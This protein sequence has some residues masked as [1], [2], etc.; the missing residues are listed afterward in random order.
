MTFPANPSRVTNPLAS[1]AQVAPHIAG[2]NGIGLVRFA[3][4]LFCA[5]TGGDDQRLCVFTF[6]Y[7]GGKITILE[8]YT[9]NPA[10]NAAITGNFTTQLKESPLY[11]RKPHFYLGTGPTTQYLEDRT[12]IHFTRFANSVYD[13]GR[14]RRILY[15][16]LR[17]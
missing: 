11:K 7:E 5:A 15:R 2:V 9:C 10:L 3:D 4:G 6:S 1:L 13:R 14:S 8:E 12:R 17:S 16:S